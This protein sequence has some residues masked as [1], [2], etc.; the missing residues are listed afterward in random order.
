MNIVHDNIWNMYRDNQTWVVLPTCPGY[1]HRNGKQYNVM[2]HG[3]AKQAAQIHP[4]L[5]EAYGSFCV[6]R[7]N[8]LFITSAEHRLILLPTRPMNEQHPHLT[9]KSPP[10]EEIIQARLKE[11]RALPEGWWGQ[12][13][14]PAPIA[15]TLVGCGA[16]TREHLD[17][18]D[19]RNFMERTFETDQ[20][21]LVLPW[22]DALRK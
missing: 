14:G 8:S 2:R 4:W 17:P 13:N 11:V 19:M 5:P 10:V 16:K 21:T 22:K 3:M 12:K 7:G 1:V 15:M 20:F 9:W 18:E 6:S